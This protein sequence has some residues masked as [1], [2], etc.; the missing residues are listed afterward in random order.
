MKFLVVMFTTLVVV[1]V[2]YID[3]THLLLV[4]KVLEVLVVAVMVVLTLLLVTI[5]LQKMGQ[6]VQAV[7]AVDKVM[8]SLLLEMVALEL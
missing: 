6:L 7:E 4:E 3:Q 1:L 2:D 8:V 5:Y